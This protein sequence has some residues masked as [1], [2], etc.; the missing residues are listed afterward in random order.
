VDVGLVAPADDAADFFNV[1][2]M[3]MDV[4]DDVVI[5]VIVGAGM[6]ML[7]L[8]LAAVVG[9]VAGMAD[10]GNDDANNKLLLA[11]LVRPAANAVV[12]DKSC[13]RE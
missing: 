2:G 4:M 8:A 5:A 9:C 1:C 11:V 13:S 12:C 6:L 10:D 7:M 3:D